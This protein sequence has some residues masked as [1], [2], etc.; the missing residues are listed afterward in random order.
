MLEALAK[1]Q[2]GIRAYTSRGVAWIILNY[3][4]LASFEGGTFEEAAFNAA[5]WVRK[6]ADCPPEVREAI[7]ALDNNYS[8]YYDA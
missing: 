8:W 7:E 6:R 5:E 2:Y 4:G 1:S 3:C